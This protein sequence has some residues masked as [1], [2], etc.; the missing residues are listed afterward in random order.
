MS[1]NPLLIFIHI[2]KTAG[3]TMSQVLARQFGRSAAWGTRWGP[4]LPAD[5]CRPLGVYVGLRLRP[6]GTWYPELPQ[7]AAFRFNQ[8]PGGRRARIRAIK[9]HMGY[10]LGQYLPRPAAHFT[11]L[12]DPV[13]RVLSHYYY[14][15]DWENRP[16][17]VDL[18]AHIRGHIEGN[19]QTRMLAAPYDGNCDLPP[20]ELLARARQ[21][22]RTCAVVGLTEH[23]DE[24]LL[25]LRKQFGWRWPVYVRINV[26]HKRPPRSAIPAETRAQL[27][28][29]NSLDV[30][31]YEFARELFAE[32]V[33]QY[34]PSFDADLRAFRSR[35]AVWL[36]WHRLQNSPRWLLGRLDRLI[37]PL[38]DPGYQALAR[39]GGLRKRLPERFRL[40]VEPPPEL[41]DSS[42]RLY[43]GEHLV[44]RY[45]PMTRRWEIR[46]PW[47]LFI[48]A[49]ALPDSG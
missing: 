12:R 7:V 44:G 46:R 27:T 41:G 38:F 13:E 32:Q 16:Q 40:R 49:D 29:D 15:A 34:G 37:W 2:P 17:D 4:R 23:F 11:L 39:W 9:G 8:L 14:T 43:L 20:D 25:L 33:R 24:T 5:T 3:L 26:N 35:Q 10:G 1:P 21:N 18:F 42:P 36:R 28:A 6:H 48:D 22:L 45:C 19:L 31:L 47:H 30:A